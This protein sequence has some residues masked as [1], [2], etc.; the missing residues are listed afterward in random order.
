MR[1]ILMMGAAIA[2]LGGGFGCS[3][4]FDR[5]KADYH[6]RRADRDAAKGN[7]YGAAKQEQ[8]AD[9]ERAHESRDILP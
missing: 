7:Y 4:S 8:K 6:Q 2:M 1:H 3:R 5:A 9:I